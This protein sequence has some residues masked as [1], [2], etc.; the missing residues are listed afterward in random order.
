MQVGDEIWCHDYRTHTRPWF[1][2]IITGETRQSWILG[3]N[4]QYKVNKKTMLESLGQWGSRR[5][6]T[7]DA[8][9]T[10]RWLD[11]NAWRI[12]K[13]VEGCHDADILKKIAV[14][15]GYQEQ[16]SDPE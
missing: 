10:K 16:P 9:N 5:W 8:R 2:E 1:K 11:R 13:A 7:D 4:S 3:N 12:A 14:L 6:Y 15:V